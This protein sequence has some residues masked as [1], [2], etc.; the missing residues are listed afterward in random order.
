MYSHDTSDASLGDSARLANDRLRKSASVVL[1]GIS[2]DYAHG[3]LFLQGRV[4]SDYCKHLAEATVDHLPG[5]SRIANQ[6]EV[7]R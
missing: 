7:V 6:I 2:C 5:V 3:V 1:R 4:P